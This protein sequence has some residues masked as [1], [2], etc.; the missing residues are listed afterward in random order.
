MA[1]KRL[2]KEAIKELTDHF[3]GKSVKDS[4][5][6]LNQESTKLFLEVRSF[7]LGKHEK[8]FLSIPAS[9]VN[10]NN[11]IRVKTSGSDNDDFSEQVLT[12]MI[13][14]DKALTG[15]RSHVPF[16]N[17]QG[18]YIHLDARTKGTEGKLAK[19]CIKHM[20]EVNDFKARKTKLETQIRGVL[21][22]AKT[23]KNLK[24]IW[25]EGYNQY[26]TMFGDPE[27]KQQAALPAVPISKLN[28]MLKDFPDGVPLP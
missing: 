18:W 22:G 25:S 17:L 26:V 2:T 16:P 5:R 1:H 21:E 24:E 9:M 15:T 6:K 7:K 14:N 4:Q 12:H 27:D 28:T 10:T 23:T 20:R 13:F 3:V 8:T 11:Q 19:R